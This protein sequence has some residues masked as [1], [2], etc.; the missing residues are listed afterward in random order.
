[1]F[2][3]FSLSYRHAFI[4]AESTEGQEEKHS[5][6][7]LRCGFCVSGGHSVTFRRITGG[8]GLIMEAAFG[9][10]EMWKVQMCM[11]VGELMIASDA[12]YH[13]FFDIEK[14]FA[15][16]SALRCD[17]A[18][19]GIIGDFVIQVDIVLVC[20]A[21]TSVNGGYQISVRSCDDQISAGKLAAYVCEGIGSGGGHAKKAGGRISEKLLEEKYGKIDLFDFICEKMNLFIPG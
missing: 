13:H 9:I 10:E 14:K 5:A 20:F 15:V 21:Y 17:Q 2:R 11:T 12:M 18:V 1:M 6:L 19:L 3:S 16:I 8:G 4:D 7:V